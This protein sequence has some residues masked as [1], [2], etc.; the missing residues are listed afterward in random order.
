M[1][2][3]TLAQYGFSTFSS[4]AYY[5]FGQ[6]NDGAYPPGVQS[7]PW[8]Y[9]AGTI[10]FPNTVSNLQPKEIRKYS[11]VTNPFRLTPTGADVRVLAFDGRWGLSRFAFTVFN[12]QQ[13][14]GPPSNQVLPT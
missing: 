3:R 14:F 5:I 7:A 2:L 6:Q 9:L 8:G 10:G 1:A 4:S 13:I 11:N 12:T